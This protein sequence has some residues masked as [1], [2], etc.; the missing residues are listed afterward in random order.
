MKSV[1]DA[2]F[3]AEELNWYYEDI[4]ISKLQKEIVLV[5]NEKFFDFITEDRDASEF[6]D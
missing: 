1:F 6:N 2:M 4:F 5:D 3:D